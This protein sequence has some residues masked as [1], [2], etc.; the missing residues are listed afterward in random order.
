MDPV[1]YSPYRL[2]D[3]G[4]VFLPWRFWTGVDNWY[5]TWALNGTPPQYIVGVA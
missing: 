3:F 4:G 2:P 5:P 1:F